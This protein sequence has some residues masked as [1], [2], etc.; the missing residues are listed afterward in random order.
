MNIGQKKITKKH[1]IMINDMLAIGQLTSAKH[2]NG[3]D[4]WIIMPKVVTDTYYG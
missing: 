1:Q 4:W 2:A 3:K